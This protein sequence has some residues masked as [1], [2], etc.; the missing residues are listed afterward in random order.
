MRQNP[1]VIGSQMDSVVIYK[2]EQPLL[3]IL[4]TNCDLQFMFLRECN[5]AGSVT[6]IFQW[7]EKS[8]RDEKFRMLFQVI[9]TDRGS[10]FSD[11]EKIEAD[12]GTW[13][14]QCRVFY[15]DPMNI[16]Q[17]SKCE[18]KHE[19]ICYII[20]KKHVKDRYTEKIRKMM[21]HINSYLRKKWNRQLRSIFFSRFTAIG[22][23]TS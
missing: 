15:C 21:S 22:L 1:D 13:K 19:L 20:P 18:R 5:T 17:K 4:F 14:I 10:E 16:N 7:L 8:L 9:L 23:Q 3:P 12:M 6:E 2:G 11:P